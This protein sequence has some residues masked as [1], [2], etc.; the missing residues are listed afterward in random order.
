VRRPRSRFLGPAAGLLLCVGA[1]AP[2][3][4][5]GRSADAPAFRPLSTSEW[6]AQDGRRHLL[7]TPEFVPPADL[8]DGAA[9]FGFAGVKVDA[10]G[11]VLFPEP[12]AGLGLVR[13]ALSY[14]DSPPPQVQVRIAVVETHCRSRRERGG[15]GLFDV[16]SLEGGGDAFFRTL[17]ATFEP[18]SWLRS[19]LSPQPFEGSNVAFGPGSGEDG[20]SDL[21]L[22]A[23]VH[24]G[25][26]RFVA[27][28]ILLCSEGIP[29]VVESAVDLP[30]TLFT[31]AQGVLA[32][33][34]TTEK[35]GVRLEVTAER[36]G[37]DHVTLL[38]HPWLRQAAVLESDTTGLPLPTLVT[39]EAK[40]RVTIP[41]GRT[42]IVGGQQTFGR[43][44]IRRGLALPGCVPSLDALD[45]SSLPID[46][47]LA[48]NNA[49]NDELEILFCATARIVRCGR[50]PPPVVP[51][52]EARR[53]A[54][55]VSRIRAVR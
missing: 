54:A 36:V 9:K 6:V 39:R 32:G 29:A 27:C 16:E 50:A 53:L 38:V 31:E 46:P 5:D 48:S 14:L 19:R 51:P 10:R 37:T 17:R 26:A 13:E 23:L 49:E 34:L 44:R 45:A 25:E 30:I 55:G 8:A 18:E 20:D 21:V 4:G 28:P 42:V 47:L 7:Y 41:D 40:T 43:L 1:R 15:H 12:A 11:R 35:A 52:C 22:R 24:E 2:V 33:K 3:F